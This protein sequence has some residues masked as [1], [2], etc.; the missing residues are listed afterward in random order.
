MRGTSSDVFSRTS[1][2]KLTPI[3][4]LVLL[5]FD[6]MFN[7]DSIESIGTAFERVS[8]V[9]T[10]AT[11]TQSHS[12]VVSGRSNLHNHSVVIIGGDLTIPSKY[13]LEGSS[14]YGI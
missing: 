13:H 3:A 9:R 1:A 8:P 6:N 10:S 5:L 2:S 7:D 14:N 12:R 11:E 4:C